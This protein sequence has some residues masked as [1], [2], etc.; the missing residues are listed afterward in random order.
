MASI[1]GL[2]IRNPVI[3][4]AGVLGDSPENLRA[5]YEAGA[6]AVV[7]KSLTVDPRP[8][9]PEPTIITLENGGRLN[10]V[11]LANPG[12]AAFA[13]ALGCAD[14][15]GKSGPGY[16]VIV[17][18][19]GSD[20]T[21]F[22]HMIG[23]FGGNVAGF[24][25]NLSCPNVDG[26]GQDVGDDPGLVGRIV[27]AA[28]D[29]AAGRTVLPVFVKI[30]HHMM[31]AA[32]AALNSGAAGLT[33]INTIPATSV[34]FVTGEPV[35]GPRAGGLSGPPIKPVALRAV[36]DL[37][38]AH[39]R[40]AV[41]GCGGISTWQDAAEFLASGAAAVQVG[42]AAM[43]NLGVLGRIAGGLSARAGNNNAPQ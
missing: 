38:A 14:G 11:G 43:E 5:A 25:I 37:V 23:L 27:G 22:E 15:A 8:A 9:R 36:R 35:F 13:R 40:A 41:M 18:L 4:A 7:T 29:A 12:A 2:E 19:A 20:P 3:L 30:G 26:V 28:V 34:D 39:P 10:A 24:E 1:G 31:G 32:L 17:S 42:S 6:G 21:D 33:A 16:P